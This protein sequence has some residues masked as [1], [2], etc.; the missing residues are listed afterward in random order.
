M[1]TGEMLVLSERSLELVA[2][3]T[4]DAIKKIRSIAFKLVK[5][6]PPG[7][8]QVLGGILYFASTVGLKSLEK[9]LRELHSKTTKPMGRLA[10]DG[11]EAS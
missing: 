2:L 4:L 6:V 3:A 1:S 9:G 8:R 10:E 11:E 7:V 5:R